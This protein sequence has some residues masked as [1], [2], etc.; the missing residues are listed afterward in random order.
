MKYI[1]AGY[2]VAFSALALYG[3]GLVARRHRLEQARRAP[4]APGDGAE[5]TP[6]S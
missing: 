4:A 1:D 3:L 6:A 2:A 5:P